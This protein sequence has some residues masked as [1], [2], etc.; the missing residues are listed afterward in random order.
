MDV[1]TPVFDYLTMGKRSKKGQYKGQGHMSES[2][3]IIHTS[4]DEYS[5]Q[6]CTNNVS[7]TKDKSIHIFL[8]FSFRGGWE[9]K[10]F[11]DL[12]SITIS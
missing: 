5:E 4:F 12:N 11:K 6:V 3:L 2:S 1:N 9:C 8:F 7:Y 10:C